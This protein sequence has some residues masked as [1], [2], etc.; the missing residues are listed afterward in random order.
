MVYSAACWL[1]FQV[2]MQLQEPCLP[3]HSI[4]A[5][6]SGAAQPGWRLLLLVNL[7][8][9]LLDI[10]CSSCA[11]TKKKS[12]RNVTN[13]EWGWVTRH[14][15]WVSRSVTQS[16]PLLFFFLAALISLSPFS[17]CVSTFPYFWWISK[18]KSSPSSE[19]VGV[20]GASRRSLRLPVLSVPHGS[21]LPSNS[22]I[23]DF[24]MCHP[25]FSVPGLV[26]ANVAGMSDFPPTPLQSLQ[27]SSTQTKQQQAAGSN[28]SPEY[29][30]L[31]AESHMFA[32]PCV[33]TRVRVCFV[34]GISLCG[35]L[36]G[37]SRQILMLLE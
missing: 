2:E 10:F 9:L 37:M 3:L 5:N 15:C 29:R 24:S 23:E 21:P 4:A 26:D 30:K 31:A 32:I 34:F 25:A 13:L 20:Q 35:K 6:I 7:L 27:E 22:L 36:N 33:C 1:P 16:L 17:M 11:K 28:S 18:R 12:G 19:F 14:R 8:R